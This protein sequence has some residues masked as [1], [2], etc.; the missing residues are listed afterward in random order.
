[1]T[2]GYAAFQTNLNI[3]GTSKISSNW[4]IRITNVTSGNKTGNA[5]NAKTP[6]WTNLT[7][8][9][10]A[11]L[12]EKGDAMEYEVTV[13]NKGTFDA[14]LESISSSESNNE[15]IKISFSGYT[16]GEKLYKNST[17]T[18]KVKIEYNKD[19]TGTPTSNSNEVS[20]DLN[21]GQ[22][23]GGTIEPTTDYLLTYDYRTNGGEGTSETAYLSSNESVDLSKKGKR[24]GYTFVGWNTDKNAKEGLSVLNMPSEDTVLYAIYK[25][26]L[27]V[28][29]SK[30]EGVTGIGKTED[31]C[32]IYNNE[33]ECEITL[34]SIT[35][36]TGYNIDG[37]YNGSTK[38]GNQNIKINIKSNISLIGKSTPKVYTITYDKNYF[39]N[40]LWQG[41]ANKN[42][43][44]RVN[45]SFTET[46]NSNVKGGKIQKVVSNGG[47][48]RI[49]YNVEAY[50]L[51]LTAG[52]TYT[53]S[54]F[55]KSSSPFTI[56]GGS[57]QNGWNN[58]IEISTEWGKKVYSFVAVGPREDP[59][60]RYVAF[61]TLLGTFETNDSVEYH[62]L[63]IMEGEP[64]YETIAKTY[65]SQLGTLST[66][67]REGYT[68]DGWYTEAYGG[69]K[70]TTTTQVTKDMTLYAHYK[71]NKYNVSYNS[72]GGSSV[73]TVVTNYE[74]P[75]ALPTP[76]KAYAVT[77][78]YNGATGGNTI[79]S[80]T[81]NTT[82]NGWYRESGLTN[83]VLNTDVLIEPNNQTLYAKWTSTAIT[84]PSPTKTGYIFDGW[85]SD[86][87]LTQKVGNAGASYTPTSGQ[88][89]YAKWT[90]DV[91]N[92]S[93]S[94]SK[95]TNSITTVATASAT[96]GMK[97]RFSFSYKE[98]NS[99][100][101]WSDA[102]EIDVP[103]GVAF[104]YVLNDLNQ[105]TTYSI[106][107]TVESK[108]GKVVT[109]EVNVTTEQIPN[110][111]YSE[112]NNGEVAIN[113]P[114]GC[115]KS[116]TCTYIKDGAAPVTVTSNPIVSFG[117]NGTLVAKV[118]DGT[119]TVTASS[120]TV[121]RNDLYVSSSGNDTTGYGT[122]NKPYASIQ[123]A[124]DSANSMA[125]INVMT[126]ITQKSTITMN[127][128]KS[129][130]LQSYN[131]SGAINSI[132]RS[133]SLT[134]HII[135]QSGG[136]LI[137]K[138]IMINGNNVEAEAS[139]INVLSNTTVE[140]GTKITKANN[141]NNYGG[142]VSVNGGIFTINDGEI[143][144]NKTPTTSGAAVFVYPDHTTVDYSETCKKGTFIMNGGKIYENT[145]ANGT[146]FNAGDFTMNDGEIYKGSADRAGGI[147]NP[148]KFVMYGGSIHDNEATKSGAGLSLTSSGT[149]CGSAEIK[150][151]Y[152]KNNKITTD[153]GV[154]GGINLDSA[155]KHQLN[156]T[157]GTISNNISLY[158][159]GGIEVYEGDVTLDGAT[160]D[161]NEAINVGGGIHINSGTLT[162]KKGTISNNKASSGAGIRTTGT[163][164]ATIYDILI[165]GNKA[166]LGAGLE[167]YSKSQ[168]TMNGG[169]ISGNV[170]QKWCGGV[171]VSGDVG[172]NHT[173]TFILNGGIIRG[174]TA[175]ISDGGI[176]RSGIGTY[177]YKSGTVTGNKPANAYETS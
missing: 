79:T 44:S 171:N 1:M 74:G 28:T 46:D 114:S 42:R 29:Y 47:E 152:I 119:N 77:Y 40:D 11:N 6:T 136:N 32:N 71:V 129:I 167:I 135:N 95:T 104:P 60:S 64:T 155:C 122:I 134:S 53:W 10:E 22:A 173:A 16:K 75:Y 25:K 5:E 143:Y 118:S 26:E 150:G 19:F 21:Y 67:L 86:S 69:T 70:V 116:Y 4:D 72:N 37:W 166:N 123:K 62:S 45:V 157:G 101:D 48:T 132:V 125:N 13:E 78:N 96:S 133:D 154:G 170:A 140:S 128:N 91:I 158:N 14:K 82:F 94:T 169:E 9:M 141:I 34:P 137:L 36:S 66:P 160:I 147:W 52:K 144:G 106:R 55:V 49:Y 59:L 33:T 87:A 85:Y 51:I 92:L 56:R 41:T 156:L 164:I 126:D 168:V 159:G 68:F 73:S 120:Y 162:V 27:K 30:G 2:V 153:K 50:D 103:E 124:Y 109:K 63:E 23:E 175:N 31:S 142:A 105:N 97:E 7:A 12:Y 121:V 177:T 61:Y 35:V 102:D 89:L 98:Y 145:S 165:T 117:T 8:S 174:N 138:N 24:E 90:E 57:E 100:N 113:Y 112:T 39:E 65:G 151:G 84:L 163:A 38:V 80:N 130:T 54:Y 139:M 99:E 88:T 83:Q 108:S 93:I 58:G 20:I 146:I 43:Y 115:G 176:C 149:N 81:A 76:T 17:Q 161:S 3:K 15:A 131:V 18:I 110:P 148:G 172:S 127:S 111:T 107:V